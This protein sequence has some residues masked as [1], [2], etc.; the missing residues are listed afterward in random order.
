MN[1]ENY[2]IVDYL[3]TNAECEMRRLCYNL[4]Y[5]LSE[6]EHVGIWCELC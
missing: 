3:S 2:P 5:P 1:M 6:K 4:D